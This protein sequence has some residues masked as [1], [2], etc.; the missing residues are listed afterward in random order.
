MDR[1]PTFKLGK[2]NYRPESDYKAKTAR[3][4]R[5]KKREQ[6]ALERKERETAEKRRKLMKAAFWKCFHRG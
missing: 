1:V 6:L 2:K 3:V 4:N 5:A